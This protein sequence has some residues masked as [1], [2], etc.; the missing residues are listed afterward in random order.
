MPMN[1]IHFAVRAQRMR[2]ASPAASPFAS[3]TERVSVPAGTYASAMGNV[4]AAVSFG[5]ESSGPS[6]MKAVCGS[7]VISINVPSLPEPDPRN[8]TPSCVSVISFEQWN[9]PGFSNTAPRNPFTNG[10]ADDLA[11]G[12]LNRRRVIATRWRDFLLHRQRGQRDPAAHVARM[13]KV[14]DAVALGRRLVFQLSI[15]ANG[16]PLA[17]EQLVAWCY[18]RSARPAVPAAGR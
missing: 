16:D 17:I 6:M 12:R 3:F 2:M 18:R 15:R 1:S 8:T 14:H 10:S 13:G 11:N 7:P 5:N 9:V 4:F